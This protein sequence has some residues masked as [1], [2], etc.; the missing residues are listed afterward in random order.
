MIH[1]KFQNRKAIIATKHHKEQVIAPLLEKEL[2]I[3]CFTDPNFDTDILGT[4]SGEIERKN[5]PLTTAR[6]KC[7]SAMQKNQC[8]IGIA[9]E[10]SFGPHPS[11]FFVSA[12]EE[13]LIFIDL[14]LQLEIVVREI[15][16]DTNFNAKEIA[17]EN[18]LLE[19]A[20]SIGFP[21]HALILRNAKD[22]NTEIYKGIQDSTQLLQYFNKMRNMYHTVY[23]ETDMRAMYNPKR[24][25]V[26]QKATEKLL[27][28]IKSTC[29]QCNTPGFDISQIKKGLPCSLCG[30]PTNSILSYILQCAQCNYIEEKKYP[31]FKTEEDPMYC[32]YCNP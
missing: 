31:T 26:I 6:E 4:F 2:G 17:T 12:D 13:I 19:F 27:H 29:P 3:T 16:S 1:S 30:L 15:S 28:K 5:D 25:H 14:A 20:D 24:M 7:I 9:S 11:L 10:G 23:V 18:E 32:D 21:S 22:S 8:D